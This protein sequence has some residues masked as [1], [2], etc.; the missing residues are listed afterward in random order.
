MP[1]RSPPTLRDMVKAARDRGQTLRQLAQ[2]AIDPETG[3]TASYSLFFDIEHGKLSRA[4][5]IEHVRAIAVALNQPF[6]AVRQA[7]IREYLPEK[8]DADALLERARQLSAEAERLTGIAE[9]QTGAGEKPA[10]RE[11]A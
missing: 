5:A 3:Q 2:R 8:I 6:E 7:A 10:A 9:R 11:S 4:P 1:D